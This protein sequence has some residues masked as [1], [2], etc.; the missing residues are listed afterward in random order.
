LQLP[1]RVVGKEAVELELPDDATVAAAKSA[2]L[3]SCPALQSRAASL[4]WA[5][6]NE[7][8]VDSR[9]LRVNDVVACF[10]L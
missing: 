2:L 7:F 4:L 9:V 3:Q 5:V 10:L 6:N 1:A 8:A